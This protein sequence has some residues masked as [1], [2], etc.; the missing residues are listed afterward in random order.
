MAL[1]AAAPTT[2][3]A[4]AR[5]RDDLL[6]WL[7][8]GRPWVGAGLQDRQQVRWP[9]RLATVVAVAIAAWIPLLQLY[10]IITTPVDRGPAGWVMA[11]T[12]LSMPVQVWLVWSAAGDVWGRG[13]RWALAALVALILAIAPL[14]GVAWLPSFLVPAVLV[15][16]AMRPPWS[17][18]GFA[19]LVMTPASTA[20]LL[21]RSQLVIYFI[22]AMPVT[23][24][25]LAVVV[26]LAR[27]A[28][29]L[30]AAQTTLA[31]QAVIGERLRIDGELRQTVGAA[32][33]AIAVQ[34]EH[35]GVFAAS[36][37]QGAA[38]ELEALVR[39]AR[40]TLAT[41]RQLVTRYQEVPL[42]AELEATVTLLAAAGIQAHLALPPEQLPDRLDAA[43]R[44][45]LRRDLARVL[46]QEPARSAVTITVA[47]RNG[48]IQVELRPGGA[49]PAAA[50]ATAR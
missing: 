43:G 48:G 17:L 49:D 26:W 18:L 5:P 47:R 8:M 38:R 34:G 12:L 44:A 22:L 42:R 20:M 32:L 21:G 11:A 41:A 4:L 6:C 36:D 37:S 24:V 33:E 25:T 39:A 28:R 16:I 29:H 35:A 3:I 15:L 50:E 9:L 40:Q 10:R 1:S 45:T 14:A 27:A 30:E 7:V 13:Q 2:T 19:A 46:G 31:Q 23:A